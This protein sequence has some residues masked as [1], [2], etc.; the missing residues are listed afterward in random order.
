MARGTVE[1]VNPGQ[2]G[3]WGGVLTSDKAR[4]GQMRIG[5]PLF[6]LQTNLYPAEHQREMI[7]TTE[8]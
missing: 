4:A 5:K 3:Q 7:E 6:Q 1:R 2:C 8:T